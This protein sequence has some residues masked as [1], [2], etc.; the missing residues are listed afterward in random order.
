MGPTKLCFHRR[1][2]LKNDR[3]VRT[4]LLVT[5]LLIPVVPWC[6]AQ[7]DEEGGKARDFLEVQHNLSTEFV[8]P[9]TEW[10]KPYTLGTVKALFFV[11][12]SQ[13][14]TEGREVIELMQRFDLDAKAVYY[15]QGSRLLGDGRPDWYGGDPEAGTN[16]ALRLLD[17]RNEVLFFNQLQPDPLP[18]SVRAAIR[19]RVWEGAGLVMV[20]NADVAAFHK[21]VPLTPPPETLPE[22]RY[23]TY[24]KGQIAL[25]PSREKLT[26]QLGWETQL[27]YQ[28]ADQGRAVLWA[29][30]REA[31]V[32][33]HLSVSDEQINRDALP[34]GFISVQC[35]GEM[36]GTRLRFVLHRWDGQKDVLN[37]VRPNRN[38]KAHVEIPRVR[39]G[40][41]HLDAFILRKNTIA[42]WASIPFRVVAD[43]EVTIAELD[44]SCAEVGEKTSGRL[45]VSGT[46]RPEDR[47]Q[48]RLVD[49]DDRILARKDVVPEHNTARFN[50]PV[51]ASL[52]MLV[53][54]EAVILD[55]PDEVS[56][57]Y[58][59]LQ[60]TKRNRNQ[61]NF[62]MWNLAT[63][64]LAPYCAESLARHGVTAILQGGTPPLSMSENGLAYVPYTMSFRASSHTTT[65]ML[66]PE[67]GILKTGCVHDEAGM[68]K[69]V[70][71]AVEGAR[72]AR[73]LGVLAYSLGDENAVRASCL[74]PQCLDAYRRYLQKVYGDIAALNR[75]WGTDYAAFDAVELMAEGDLPAADAPEWFKDYFADWDL[76]HRTDNEGAKGEALDRQ[77]AMGTVNDEL[78][79]LQAGNFARWY[80]R[81]AFQN[82]TYVEW[83]QEFQKAYR[84]LDAQAWTGFEGTDSFSIRKL[85]T[86]S[87]QGGDLD[88]F[89][90]EMDYFG[91]YEGPANEVVRSIAPPGFPRGNWIGYDPDVEVLLHKY[92]GQVTDSMNTI[93]WWRWDNLDGYHGYLM[94]TLAPFPAVREL[95]DD[96]AIVRDGLGTLLMHCRMHDNRIG[97]L[98]SMP[99]TYIAHFDRN[100]TYGKYKRDH[101]EWHRLI[102]GA[103]FQFR[104][105]TDRMLRLGEFEAAHY[106]ILVLP[107]AFAMGPDEAQ[108]IRE[109]VKNGGTVIA[110]LRPAI[111]DGHCKPLEVGLLDDVF[112]IERT[113]NREAVEVD[114]LRVDGEL[115]GQRLRMDWGNWH[116]RDVYPQMKVDPNVRL[117]TGQEL[118]HAYH[119][120]YWV[121][122]ES[123]LGIVNVFGEGR[124]ILLNFSIFNAPADQFIGDLFGA[125]GVEPAVPVTRPDGAPLRNVEVTRW[126]NGDAVLLALFGTYE[127]DACVR[128]PEAR[129]VYDLK[130]HRYLGDVQEFTTALRPNRASLFA[131]QPNPAGAPELTASQSSVNPG[132]RIEAAIRVVHP[133]SKQAVQ[134]RLADPDGNVVPWF[135]KVVIGGERPV[136]VTVPFAFNDLPGEWTFRATDL[137]SNETAEATLNLR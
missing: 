74:S 109:F 45:R 47:V 40:D 90:R 73:E 119:I 63:G 133:G 4:L 87:R 60:V 44:K 57:A 54:V 56:S 78:R 100:E 85:T 61:F 10:G 99:S 43:R 35:S 131:L 58:A 55:G 79:A 67:T 72:K 21:A 36:R 7:E 80:D 136:S 96:T 42:D 89:V 22:G 137:F 15:L 65:A 97:M 110:D 120:H 16:R 9:H 107:L 128:L 112:G 27:D 75:E 38:G 76:L 64:D 105:V 26:F 31:N 117:T 129:Y 13:G 14:S 115:G 101:N 132:D 95:L 6:L 1:L 11:P 134:V 93:Q 29:A 130:Q 32:D 30:R 50:F 103:G 125:C 20:G 82:Q 71:R 135:H 18:E 94:P 39:T 25:L 34:K 8:T 104:Y 49:R 127:G 124:A 19:R 24:G 12:W 62:V 37:T 68:R 118:G 83:C 48:V 113:G 88:A 41:Y 52:P 102:H 66:D 46:L 33:L 70:A 86:R 126:Q 122:L 111:Y 17:E 77:V 84:E 121:G 51:D 5:A 116:G 92:W 2:F 3:A 98:Y 28:L 69:T 91:P 23:F 108:V 106:K 81:Q 53:R 114:R 123:P 59:Y